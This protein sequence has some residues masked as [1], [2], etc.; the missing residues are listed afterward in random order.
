MSN[1][2][3]PIYKKRSKKKNAVPVWNSVY[4]EDGD[5]TE[6]PFWWWWLLGA[7]KISSKWG[8]RT[9]LSVTLHFLCFFVK[10]TQ[11][12]EFPSKRTNQIM[13]TNTFLERL[14]QL[15]KEEEE[16]EEE[17][18]DKICREDTKENSSAREDHSI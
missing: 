6:N 11:R 4:T 17:E 14:P 7:K 1:Q 15:K 5:L 12:T 2:Q 9:N 3:N 18:T 16:E 10:Q 13:C 8:R